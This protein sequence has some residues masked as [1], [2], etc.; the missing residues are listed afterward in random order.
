[1][2]IRSKYNPQLQ[3]R[4]QSIVLSKEQT[5][6][7]IDMAEHFGIKL[8]YFIRLDLHAFNEELDF[9]RPDYEEE[10][11]IIAFARIYGHSKKIRIWHNNSFNLFMKLAS[12]F[13][14]YC[15][16]SDDHIFIDVEGN[17]LPCFF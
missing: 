17:V 4:L 2:E 1:M 12:C 8:I 6:R 13:D 11:R 16:L 5:K 15:L 7:I 10:K 14:K 3:A 9:R